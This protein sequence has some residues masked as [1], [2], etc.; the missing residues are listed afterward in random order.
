MPPNATHLCQPLDV[1]VFRGLKQSWRKILEK[2][3]IESR[4]HGAIPKEHLPTLLGR[5]V[6]DLQ[7]NSLIS[8]FRA[9]GIYPLDR[10]QV[11]KRLPGT[12]EDQESDSSFALNSSVID[13]LK[14][15]LGIGGNKDNTKKRREPK[16]PAGKQVTSLDKENH[17]PSDP[18]VPT[19]SGNL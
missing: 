18:N 2:W 16:V 5:L 10:N 13:L 9:S 1:A 15:N 4:V 17:P 6:N 14:E 12:S 19:T 7:P 11:L 8:G 3:R